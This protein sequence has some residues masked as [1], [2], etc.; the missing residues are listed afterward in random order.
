MYKLYLFLTDAT[1]TIALDIVLKCRDLKMT[2]QFDKII[3]MMILR[4][5]YASIYLK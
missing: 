1:K 3:V 4:T 5:I 2:T